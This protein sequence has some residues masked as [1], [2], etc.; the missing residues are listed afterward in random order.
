MP[1]FKGTK[2]VLATTSA[3]LASL[4]PGDK[5]VAQVIL[6]E[7]EEVIHMT[8]VE[9]AGRAGTAESTTI[10]CCR[11]LGYSGFQDLKIRLAREL[12]L[13]KPPSIPTL[14]T[15]QTPHD[16]LRAI[17]SFNRQLLDDVNITIESGIFNEAAEALLEADNVLLTGFG[18]SYFVCLDAQDR[19]SSIGI[20]ARAPEAPNMKLLQAHR[21]KEGDVLI[22]VSHTGATKE[23]LRY[24]DI[25][26][27]HGAH[28]IGVTSSPRSKLA[29]VSDY[30][31]AVGGRELDFR[32]DS[33]SARIV[34][35]SVLD[36]LYLALAQMLGNS[37]NDN[38]AIFHDEESVW[39]L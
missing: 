12:S 11:K 36:S 34:H 38:L 14:S 19:L 35:L 6:D 17:V 23:I 39:R 5:K 18:F 22:C 29:R 2:T 32:I 27:N 37:A 33:A 7:P 15:G 28:S 10:R 13:E 4:P 8:V 30:S 20:N 16:V 9:L 21:L 26:K 25:A 3:L 31:L 24:V 1:D